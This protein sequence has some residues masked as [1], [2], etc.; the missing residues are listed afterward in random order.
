MNIAQELAGGMPTANLLTGLGIDEVFSRA[1][2]LGPKS[3][4]TDALGTTVALTDSGGSVRTSYTYEPYGNT[5]VS[6]EANANATQYSGR[7]NDGTGLY[8]YR[9]RYYDP[10]SS[11]FVTEDPIGF[12]G[13][14]NIYAY[15][16]GNPISLRDSRGLDNPGMGRTACGQS[17]R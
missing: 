5:T 16:G 4:V 8:Y 13:G 12:A 9:A 14:N 10:G 7:E 17:E 6:G 1:D 11:R 15:V 3:F 2:S